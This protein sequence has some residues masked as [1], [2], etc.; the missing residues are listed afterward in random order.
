[1]YDNSGDEANEKLY[2]NKNN[3]TFCKN[4]EFLN[5]SCK[6]IKQNSSVE[7]EFQV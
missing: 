4:Y 7:R 2:G 3:D 1:M 5:E 6:S